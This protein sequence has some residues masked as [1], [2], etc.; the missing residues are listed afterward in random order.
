MT[1]IR[2]TGVRVFL[3]AGKLELWPE[4]KAWLYKLKP[5]QDQDKELLLAQIRDAGDGICGVQPIR[6]QPQHLQKRSSGRIATCA[7]CAEPYPAQDGA[8]CRACQGEAPYIPGSAPDDSWRESPPLKAV[9]VEQAVGKRALHDMTLILPGKSK[10]A[11]FTHGQQITVGDLC[12]LQQMGRRTIY[13]EEENRITPEWVHENQAAVAFAQAMAGDGVTFEEPP[14]E[15]RIN[16]VADRDGLLLV[17]EE[18][19]EQFNMIPGVMCA[20]RRSCTVVHQQRTVAATRAIPLLI[21]RA[22][23][24]KAL[25]VLGD[26]PL[27]KVLPMRRAR[28]GILVTGSEV[29]Q[30]LIEDQFVPIITAKVERHGCSVVQSLIVP[31]DRRA[32]VDGIANLVESGADLVVTTAGLSVDP[33]DVTRQGLIDAGATD[34]LHGAPIIPGAMLLLANIGTVQ[35]IGV[36]ACALYFKTTGFDLL[37][38]RLLAGLKTTRRD[39]AKLGHGAFCLAC[40]TCTFP[41]CPFGG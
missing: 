31:D 18:R 8:I 1:N 24:E 28:V 2:E 7:L 25:I 5:K 6:I 13:L 33:D 37:L 29:F 10:G 12:R 14:R 23:F 35:V 40:K 30:G 27:F 19:L 36:P 26:A 11:A 16:L 15:G 20:G 39:L 21:P 17:D 3:D 34:L 22:D 9:S 38:P 4:I 32:I 41:K